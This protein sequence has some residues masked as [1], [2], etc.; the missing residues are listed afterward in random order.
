MTKQE[1]I[2]EAKAFYHDKEPQR[3]YW[4]VMLFFTGL[5]M[6]QENAKPNQWVNTNN[7]YFTNGTEALNYYANTPCPA[8]QIVDGV[9]PEDLANNMYEMV[10]NYQNE[11]WLNKELYPYL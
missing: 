10:E 6:G 11:E 2:D 7:V 4:G 8:S 5:E 1:Y 3:K 9:S